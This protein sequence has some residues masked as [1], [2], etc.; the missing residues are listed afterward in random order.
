MS[1]HIKN[2]EKTYDILVACRQVFRDLNG[3]SLVALKKMER[4]CCEI[5]ELIEEKKYEKK[6]E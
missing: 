3:D 4:L 6:H 5:D 1:R 2:I